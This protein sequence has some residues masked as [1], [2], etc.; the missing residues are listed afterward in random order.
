MTNI[1]IETGRLTA[2]PELR[3]TGETALCKLG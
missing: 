2:A 1:V 3:R